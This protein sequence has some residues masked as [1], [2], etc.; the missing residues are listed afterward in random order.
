MWQEWLKIKINAAILGVEKEVKGVA[1][2]IPL[3][4]GIFAES[5]QAVTKGHSPLLQH[6]VE[7]ITSYRQL[8]EIFLRVYSFVSVQPSSLQHRH[9]T[10]H[11]FPG[12]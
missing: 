6:M 12:K 4:A 5:S 10:Q 9:L 7:M 11:C 1:A 8:R 3:T 2:Q